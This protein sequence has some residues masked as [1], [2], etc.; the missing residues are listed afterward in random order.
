MIYHFI[1]EG[2][3]FTSQHLEQILKGAGINDEQ[4]Q[5]VINFMLYYGFVGVKIGANLPKFIFD[6]A[7]DMKLVAVLISKAK[8]DMVYVLNPAFHAGLNF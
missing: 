1:G 8:N 4:I 3:S 2:D 5:G 7:Y 6:V